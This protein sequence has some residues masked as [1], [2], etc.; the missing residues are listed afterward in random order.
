MRAEADDEDAGV[1]SQ[2]RVAG[3]VLPLNSPSE[4]D[5]PKRLH[6][7]VDAVEK[8]RVTRVARLLEDGYD[9]AD[10]RCPV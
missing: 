10:E 4:S 5:G 8:S 9:L 7:C 3:P 2:A 6:D 1:K